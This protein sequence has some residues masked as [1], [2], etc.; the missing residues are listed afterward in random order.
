MSVPVSIGFP[1]VRMSMAAL[2]C[3]VL[4][5]F[6]GVVAAI[7][8][9]IVGH[10]ARSRIKDN[11]YRFGGSRLALVGLAISYL[12]LLMSLVF[13]TCMFIYPEYLELLADHTG[14][15]LILAESVHY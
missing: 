4:S 5:L 10:I 9:I 11:P 15:S 2:F 14:Q 3:G 12:G 1:S 13:F 6:L 8:G 7:P